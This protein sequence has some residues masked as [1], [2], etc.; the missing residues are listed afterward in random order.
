MLPKIPKLG[1]ENG[2][3]SCAEEST[4]AVILEPSFLGR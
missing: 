1:N 2:E 4:Q 3:T